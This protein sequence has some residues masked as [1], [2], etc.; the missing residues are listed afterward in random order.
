MP[1]V[2]P[3]GRSAVRAVC[4]RFKGV[5]SETAVFILRHAQFQFMQRNHHTHQRQ[6]PWLAH[7]VPVGVVPH[8]V[9]HDADLHRSQEY[10]RSSKLTQRIPAIF[11]KTGARL[12]VA[13]APYSTTWATWLA[14]PGR[15]R[16]PKA[17]MGKV[18]PSTTRSAV[19]RPGRRRWCCG[20]HWWGNDRWE[21][22]IDWRKE[23]IFSLSA[24]HRAVTV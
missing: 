7:L 13:V 5:E 16:R 14:S 23:Q 21:S 24:R 17:D 6:F 10:E 22:T 12:E 4:S 2:K 19:G 18:R 9:A 11:R 15:L 1:A 20:R 3:A 8:D